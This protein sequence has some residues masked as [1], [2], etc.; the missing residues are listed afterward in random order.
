[1]QK[2]PSIVVMLTQ[3]YDHHKQQLCEAMTSGQ[4]PLGDIRI[5][6]KIIFLREVASTLSMVMQ[7]EK[8]RSKEAVDLKLPDE[9]LNTKDPALNKKNSVPGTVKPIDFN[10]FPGG[11]QP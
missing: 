2:T 5:K 9:Q 6:E 4:F 8:L 7:V 1:M 10:S 11:W 3:L